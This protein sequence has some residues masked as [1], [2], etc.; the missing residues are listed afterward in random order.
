VQQSRQHAAHSLLQLAPVHLL[1]QSKYVQPP[2][3]QL[4]CIRRWERLEQRRS[5]QPSICPLLQH[6]AAQQLHALSVG[7]HGARHV[8]CWRLIHA[9]PQLTSLE[10]E[11]FGMSDSP[12]SPQLLEAVS[13]CLAQLLGRPQ[14]T[15]LAL[16]EVFLEASEVIVPLLLQSAGHLRELH[17]DC[18][19][20]W[21]A[22]ATIQAQFASLGAALP[23]LQKLSLGVFSALL[24]LPA[25]WRRLF[26]ALQAVHTLRL[27]WCEDVDALLPV[28]TECAQLR[29]LYIE[30][31]TG[32]PGTTASSLA[33]ATLRAAIPQLRIEQSTDTEE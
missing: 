24:V 1:L 9:L 19:F 33:L 12:V 21:E 27:V 22:S 4:G 15:S 26:C 6:P 28:L 3:L 5:H 7:Q 2:S 8:E 13:Q 20:L 23:Q 31:F 14:L 32:W 29:N 10:A 16:P 17:L 30:A 25:E 18:S 11:V